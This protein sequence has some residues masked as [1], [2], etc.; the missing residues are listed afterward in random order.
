MIIS[1]NYKSKNF[2]D[3]LNGWLWPK[4]IPDLIDDNDT[5]VLVGIGTI[6]NQKLRLRMPTAKKFIVFSS[7]VGYGKRLKLDSSI[8]FYCVRGPLSAKA[9]N[10]SPELGI[11]DGA[12][13][14]KK[15]FVAQT[16]KIYKY[17]YMPHIDFSGEGW[18]LTCEKL[19]FGY[20]DPSWPIETVISSIQ[21]TEILL[22]EAMHGAIIADT[23]RI[24]WVPII[25][26]P[27]INSFKWQDWCLS[28]NLEYQSEMINRLHHPS[29]KKDLLSPLRWINDW[30]RQNLAAKE[31]DN[32]SKKS[33]PLLSNEKHLSEL[34][35]RLEEKLEQLKRD[36]ASGIYF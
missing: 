9:L 7:G 10:L 19:G 36:F 25:S 15:F 1:Y 26:H 29:Q 35:F 14:V 17:S 21:K 24:P 5:E 22:T 27:I 30:K 32:I 6:L 18:Q 12:V 16:S 31:L 28:I 20:I 4:I 34:I 23:F 8:K 2:G 3:K 13:L 33:K 11:T